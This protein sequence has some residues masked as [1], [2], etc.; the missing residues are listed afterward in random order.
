[1]NIPILYASS[2][3]VLLATLGVPSTG[4]AAE[5]LASAQLREVKQQAQSVRITD[6]SV[7]VTGSGP[8]ANSVLIINRRGPRHSYQQVRQQVRQQTGLQVARTSGPYT[9]TVETTGRAFNAE[10]KVDGRTIQSLQGRSE[11]I[12]LSPHLS[13]GQHTIE[14]IGTYAPATATAEISL[15]GPGTRLSQQVSGRGVLRQT[16]QL[17]V[18]P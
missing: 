4:L 12:N 2:L 6:S 14:I 13:T 7:E 11:T 8:A 15:S 10:L 3:T 18:S 16:L 17:S 1:M 9:L 5:Y